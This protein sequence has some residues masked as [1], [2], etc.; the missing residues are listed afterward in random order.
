MDWEL[1]GR[2]LLL[3]ALLAIGSHLL[4]AKVTALTC[5]ICIRGH[6]LLFDVSGQHK[7]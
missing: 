6:G 5:L 3:Q 7:A 1:G 2:P 4:L